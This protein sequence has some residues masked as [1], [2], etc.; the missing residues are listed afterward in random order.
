M[1]LNFPSSSKCNSYIFYT[2]KLKTKRMK[3]KFPSS[4]K[5]NS[6]IFYT[7]KLKTKNTY[8][9]PKT[10]DEKDET[11]LPFELTPKT[12][13][14][15][16]VTQL[17]FELKVSFIHILHSKNRRWSACNS[18]SLRVQSVIHTYFTPENPRRK[19]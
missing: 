4:S 8:F 6:Y 12:E 7:R 17:P 15:V 9:T 14:G 11:Q 3:L 19:G 2:R 13:D 5:C 18:T 1:Q 10:Q 16:H